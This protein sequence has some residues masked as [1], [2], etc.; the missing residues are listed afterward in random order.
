MTFEQLQVFLELAKTRSM[1]LCASN[2]YMSK[3]S[4]SYSISQ[5]ENE[6]GM[7][8]FI[9]SH[10]G[11]YLTPAG[12]EL[13]DH[14]ERLLSEYNQIK[15][16][17]NDSDGSGEISIVFGNAFVNTANDMKDLLTEKSNADS[18]NLSCV[19]APHNTDVIEKEKPDVV[20]AL[21]AENELP[22]LER[23][24]NDYLGYCIYKSALFAIVTKNNPTP[25][26]KNAKH[27]L[28]GN[29]LKKLNIA[30]FDPMS[31]YGSSPQP[32]HGTVSDRWGID[33]Q[34]QRAHSNSIPGIKALMQQGFVLISD[35]FAL[36]DTLS[37][38][39]ESADD[40]RAL[41]IKPVETAIRFALLRRSSPF[42]ADIGEAL[43]TMYYE[44]NS[45]FQQFKRFL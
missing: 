32:V 31:A 1:S 14:A 28:A 16:M 12:E 39:L 25:I 8:L 43:A 23:Y 36:K 13:L 26:V 7:R 4:V 2:L 34:L 44:P 41:N 6:L 40:Y 19:L 24:R 22:Q 15:S 20:F 11:S 10:D 37:W 35:R 9:K 5:L 29:E 45:R 42:F 33:N 27:A 21:I 38:V 18:I 3:S 17:K 30:F